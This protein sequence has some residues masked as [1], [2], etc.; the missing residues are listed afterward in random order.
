MFHNVILVVPGA[1]LAH[2]RS[3]AVGVDGWKWL[4]INT[5]KR[6]KSQ[7]NSF[8]ELYMNSRKKNQR[9]LFLT[10]EEDPE[11]LVSEDIH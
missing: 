6:F 7:Q 10:F 4:T 9:A 2:Y 1:C 8:E 11:S 3:T 5:R